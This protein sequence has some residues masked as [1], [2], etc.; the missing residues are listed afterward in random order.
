MI[1]KIKSAIQTAL[2][3]A[4]IHVFDPMNDGQHFQ[5]VVISPS[6]EG[7]SLVK[8][9]QSVM[10]PLKDEFASDAVHALGLKTFT[11]DKWE[12][13]KASYGVTD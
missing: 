6:F 9:H 12:S 4:T 8:Q 5:A 11:P 1:E 10:K 13:A 7:I 3:D 2:P